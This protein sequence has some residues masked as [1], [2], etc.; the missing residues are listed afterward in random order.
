MVQGDDD[1]RRLC[2]AIAAEDGQ[3]A[4]AYNAAVPGERRLRDRAGPVPFLGA[5]TT[6][7]VVLLLT[8][9]QLD[10]LVAAADYA[11]Q[12]DGWPFGPLHGDAPV[13]LYEWWQDRL[14]ALVAE[15][16]EQHVSNAVAALF[17]TPWPSESF[18][19][20]LRLPSRRRM[21]ELAAAAAGRDAII[22]VLRGAELWT[23][24]AEVAALPPTRRFYPK[25]W[26]TTRLTPDNL[27]DGAWDTVCRR[28]EVHA[29]L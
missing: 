5:V 7:P 15:F 24:H 8:H 20:R 26:R 6:A 10:T 1:W 4:A 28:V 3:A 14:G 27:G 25:S 23:E 11:F 17:L 9:P 29:W 16:G 22:V 2:A 21:L 19:T 18:D 12:R 13:G